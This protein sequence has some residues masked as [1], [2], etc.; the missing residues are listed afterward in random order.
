[1]T[2]G[3]R[4]E[5]SRAAGVPPK[6][7][8][9]QREALIELATKSYPVKVGMHSGWSTRTLEALARGGFVT[10]ESRSHSERRGRS[11]VETFVFDGTWCSITAAGRAAVATP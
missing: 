6:L 1:M 10:L 7:T 9:R 3:P 4:A 5:A 11:E 2:R 8:A